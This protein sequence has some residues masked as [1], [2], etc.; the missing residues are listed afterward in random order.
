MPHVLKTVIPRIRRS[1][2][3]RGVLVSLQRSLLLPVHLIREY[4]QARRLPQ[5]TEPSEFDLAFGVQT[6]GDRDGW[7][8]LSDLDI[9]SSNWISGIDYRGIEPERFAAALRSVA[10]EPA[11]FT[12][13]DFGSGKGRALLLASQ[14]PFRRVIGIEFSPELHAIAQRNIH[15]FP[16]GPDACSTVES[17]CMDF[18]DFDLPPDPS[19]LF[20]YDPCSETIFRSLLEKIRASLLAY[21]RLVHLIYVAPGRKEALLDAAAF[22]VK[23]GHNEE[24]YFSWYRS[25]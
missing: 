22:L 1:I 8:Y 3:E 7:T 10:M 15:L 24:L 6:D 18:L 9:P 14:L 4:R 16:H 25:R 17:R 12:F 23:G 13:I 2:A 19:V 11:N 21:P 20:F 5:H